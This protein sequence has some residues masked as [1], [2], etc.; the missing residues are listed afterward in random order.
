VSIQASVGIF[1]GENLKRYHQEFSVTDPAPAAFMA[2][3]VG[4]ATPT[5]R[6]LLDERRKPG[7]FF[8]E[9]FR[10]LGM[11]ECLAER[12]HRPGAVSQ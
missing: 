7:I 2:Q 5:Y 11:E 4:T 10:P 8:G 1:T 3:P 9:F 12:S 6:L